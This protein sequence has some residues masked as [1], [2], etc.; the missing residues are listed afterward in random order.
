MTI[1]AVA[2]KLG[3]KWEVAAHLVRRGLLEA[4]GDEITAASIDRFSAK[5]VSGVELARLEGTS[6][7]SLERRLA[8]GGVRPV[9]GR[10]VDGGRQ[11]FF[12]RAE[13]KRPG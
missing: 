7:R 1:R 6:A 2:W 5:Y 9:S 11:N 13:V 8:E 4:A 12:K 10:E 3:I